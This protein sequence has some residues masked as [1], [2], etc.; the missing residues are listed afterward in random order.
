MPSEFL[1]RLGHPLSE[2]VL[3]AGK[4]TAT[5]MQAVDFI[6]SPHPT[7]ISVVE[8]P[9][10]KRGWLILPRLEKWADDQV[11]GV[12][13]ELQ[14]TKEQIKDLELQARQATTLQD[15]SDLQLRIAELEKKKRRQRQQVFD[16]EDVI[17][18]RRDAL[19]SAR[20]RRLGHLVALPATGIIPAIEEFF[21]E[22]DG[23][24]LDDAGHDEGLEPAVA[25]GFVEIHGDGAFLWLGFFESRRELSRALDGCRWRST[26]VKPSSKITQRLERRTLNPRKK[27][28]AALRRAHRG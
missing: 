27:Y 6:I 12:E 9:K 25:A 15:Q 10:G 19:I 22:P 11:H 14:Q 3:Q 28:P 20:Q 23:G 4:N 21:A 8:D 7:R 17:K 18:D 2:Y 5:P 13:R 16:T 1:C 26:A 24:E